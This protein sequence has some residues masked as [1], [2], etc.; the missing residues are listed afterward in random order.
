ML[1]KAFFAISAH[2]DVHSAI[3]VAEELIA[4]GGQAVFY[5]TDQFT[6]RVRR[7]GAGFRPHDP[8]ADLYERLSAASPLTRW[9]IPGIARRTRDIAATVSTEKWA[10]SAVTILERIPAE[11]D[12]RGGYDG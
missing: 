7:A 10:A 11:H 3:P 8:A 4:R 5:L 2:S 12:E 9:R 1:I 6:P